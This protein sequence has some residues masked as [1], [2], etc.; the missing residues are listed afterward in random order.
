MDSIDLNIGTDANCIL[1]Y[2]NNFPTQFIS[3][4]EIA[5]RAE[6]RN[7]FAE[8]ARWTHGALSELMELNMVETDGHGR[9]RIKP[10]MAKAS[11][12]GRKFIDPKLRS[13]LEKS[14]QKIDLS[15]YV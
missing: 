10:S 13:I 5:R 8:D 15:S 11:G 14:G 4:M 12:H 2:L 7:R 3:E 9:Y 1:Q 6:G